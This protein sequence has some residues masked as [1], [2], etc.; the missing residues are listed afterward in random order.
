VNLTAFGVLAL[1]AAG[2]SSAAAVVRG[3]DE[4]LERQQEG[5]GGFGYSARTPGGGGSDV[6][7]TGAVLQALAAGG[8]ARGSVVARAVAFIRSAQNRDGGLPE[9][10]GG[11]SN[12]QST[13]WAIQGLAAVGVEASHVSRH[14]SRSPLAYLESLIGPAGSVRYSAGDEQTPVWV[15]AEALVALD[16]KPFPL[17]P[18]RPA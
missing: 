17:P 9:Q 10:P 13:A 18:R 8:A 5:D 3:A 4:W 14:G 15:T 6:D 16:G 11:G 7:D 1:R 12:A 2:Y